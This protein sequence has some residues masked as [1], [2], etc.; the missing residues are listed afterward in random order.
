MKIIIQELIANYK[1]NEKTFES[2][3]LKLNVIFDIFD[4]GRDTTPT[5]LKDIIM[6]NYKE[7]IISDCY[8]EG[9]FKKFLELNNYICLTNIEM[10]EQEKKQYENLQNKSIQKEIYVYSLMY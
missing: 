3:I 8:Y 6:F 5:I 2:N 1:S 9:V 10:T 4:G 7:Q